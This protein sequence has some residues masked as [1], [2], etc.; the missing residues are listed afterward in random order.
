MALSNQID[1]P[2]FFR[3]RE[4]TYRNFVNSEYDNPLSTLPRKMALR[5]H[6]LE[7]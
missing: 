5:R 2:G 4:M 3:L 1:F 7:N 6:V